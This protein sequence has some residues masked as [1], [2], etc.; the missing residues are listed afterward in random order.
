MYLILEG[1]RAMK[2]DDS[3]SWLLVPAVAPLLIMTIMEQP[4]YLGF[5][6]FGAGLC[7][8]AARSARLS[9]TYPTYLR[10][11]DLRMPGRKQFNRAV[12][13]QNP[14]SV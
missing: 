4:T 9:T 2:R 6:V 14:S 8:A 5:M 13:D 3:L 7:L 10:G 1:L 12:G 11:T